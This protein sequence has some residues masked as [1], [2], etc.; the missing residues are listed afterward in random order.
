MTYEGGL[1]RAMIKM[2]V[3]YPYGEAQRFDMD[4]Y[5]NKHV[6]MVKEKVGAALVGVTVERGLGG[7]GPG[8]PPVYSVIA[9]LYFE[10]MEALETHC[11]PHSPMF[12]ADVPNF[13]DI[14]P[15]IQISEVVL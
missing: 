9:Q 3:F 6:A 2:T 11:A 1:V 10:S 13:T 4:Y 5:V 12:D 15:I 8:M 7:P 14:T